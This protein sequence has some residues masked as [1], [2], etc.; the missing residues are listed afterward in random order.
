MPSSIV[1]LISMFSGYDEN[2][3]AMSSNVGMAKSSGV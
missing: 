1:P 3:V 2:R